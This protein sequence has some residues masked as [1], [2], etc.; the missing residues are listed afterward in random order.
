[1]QRLHSLARSFVLDFDACWSWRDSH[2]CN[3]AT[4]EGVNI[5]QTVYLLSR[6]DRLQTRHI[7]NPRWETNIPSSSAWF[8]QTTPQN[9]CKR[10]LLGR[11]IESGSARS[12][13]SFYI[14]N[15]PSFKTYIMFD[16]QILKNLPQFRSPITGPKKKALGLYLGP[17]VAATLDLAGSKLESWLC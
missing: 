12:V 8:W 4:T 1:M 5:S 6:V 10:Y 17:S 11:S 16:T 2:Q 3:I 13:L 14:L 15:S 7:A 9:D